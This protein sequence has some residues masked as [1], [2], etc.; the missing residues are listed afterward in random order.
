MHTGEIRAPRNGLKDFDGLER[1]WDQV[2]RDFDD[3]LE[4]IRSYL[5][6]PSVS[7]TGEG[8]PECAAMT[9]DLIEMAG[10][11]ARVVPTDGHPAVVGK[12]EGPGPT[13]LR[14]GMY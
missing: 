13:L 11:S 7:G 8:I 3:H 14:Y 12:V 10:G 4:A 6:Q 5:K 1:A 9:A 2:D